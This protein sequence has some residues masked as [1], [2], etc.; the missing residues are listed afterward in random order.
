MASSDK[1]LAPLFR[2]TPILRS[3]DLEKAGIK[4]MELS[5]Y[6]ATG[7]VRRI[8]RGVYC[9]PDFRQ[10]EHGDLAIVATRIP[11]ALV[12]LLSALRYHELTTQAPSEIWIAI[13]RKARS[14][15]LDFP[16]LK[17]V[18]F[19]Q[20]ALAYGAETKTVEG[21]KVRITTIEK[22][23]ADCFKYRNKVG[24][25]AALEALRDAMAKRLIDQDELWRCAKVDR[26][27]GVIRPYLEAL[28]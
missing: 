5:R 24:L 17:V 12:C 1:R 20:A 7:K 11:G 2:G 6:L 22:T 13:D 18:R 9:L 21:V 27:S 3:R 10:H 25:D 16:G 26:V 14:P 15:R 8:Q 23:I 4:R 28:A 19:D